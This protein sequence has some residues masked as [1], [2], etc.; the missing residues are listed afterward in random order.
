MSTRAVIS[1]VKNVKG[2]TSDLFHIRCRVKPNV[3]KLREGVKAVTDDAIELNVAAQPK[4][5]EANKA[6]VRIM[7]N[8]LGIAKSD[9]QIV[10]GLKSRDKT[11]EVNVSAIRIPAGQG[12]EEWVSILR[13]RLETHVSLYK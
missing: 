2:K 4:D 1:A 8:A 9:L 10:H 12:R 3:D 6:T 13:S 11:I 7:S 5:G